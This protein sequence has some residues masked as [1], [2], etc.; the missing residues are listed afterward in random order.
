M[1]YALPDDHLA[2]WFY[3][4]ALVCA[5]HH[6]IPWM[7]SQHKNAGMLI[8]TM[9]AYLWCTFSMNCMKRLLR[10]AKG[11][12]TGPKQHLHHVSHGGCVPMA[13][14]LYEGDDVGIVICQHPC[15]R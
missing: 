6:M 15:T 2:A 4:H 8:V 12:L 5:N 14:L 9:N 3:M 7:S 1:L 10:E 11:S 13:H